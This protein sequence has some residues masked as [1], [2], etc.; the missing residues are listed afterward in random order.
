VEFRLLGP[1][2]IINGR[3]VPTPTAPKVR[4]MLALLLLRANQ[5]VGI[6]SIIEELWG[7]HPPRTAVLTARTY[8][9]QLRRAFP[10]WEIETVPPGYLFR[11]EDDRLD[12]KRFE[13]LFAQAQAARS[14][15]RLEE[16]A[17][18]VDQALALWTGP[19]VSNVSS[20]RLLNNLVTSLQDSRVAA[21]QLRIQTQMRLGRH[22]DLIAELRSLVA[23]HP[24]H[25][26]FHAQLIFALNK[27]G[28]RGEALQA[29]RQVC[30]LLSDEL[31]LSPSVDLQ[32]V[33]RE[34]L[35]A[36]V[37]QPAQLRV[38]GG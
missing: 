18:S 25:E 10:E 29:Y 9:Y 5:V 4:Q 6:D 35:T 24:F 38:A 31:G 15:G 23:E 26:W 16:A 22:G 32:R 19:V 11:V 14:A 17:R 12:F 20:G 37:R 1:L 33:H 2:E 13:R 30:T 28:R 21:L 34:V 3:R 8:A 7:E 36:D 27:A